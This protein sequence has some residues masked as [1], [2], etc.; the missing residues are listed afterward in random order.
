MSLPPSQECTSLG[1]K[2]VEAGVMAQSCSE[3]LLTVLVIQ[4]PT[5]KEDLEST[6]GTVQGDKAVCSPSE[7]EAETATWPF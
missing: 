4:G 6:G 2:K 1:I 5:D 3:I 7:L